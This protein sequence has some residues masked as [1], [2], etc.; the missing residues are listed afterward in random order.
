M[1]ILQ[2]IIILVLML[3]AAFAASGTLFWLLF[4]KDAPSYDEVKERFLID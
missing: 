1:I 4:K 3:I 2:Q